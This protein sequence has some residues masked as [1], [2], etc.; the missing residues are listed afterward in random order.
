[1]SAQL[2]H[3]LSSQGLRV[4]TSRVIRFGGWEEFEEM[5]GLIEVG[6]FATGG[7]RHFCHS[8]WRVPVGVHTICYHEEIES[9]YCTSS[10]QE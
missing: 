7:L 2:A 10:T 6:T 3:A 4:G 1:M 5:G 8:F 9:R